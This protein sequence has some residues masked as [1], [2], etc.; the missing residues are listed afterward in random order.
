MAEVVFPWNR[1]IYLKIQLISIRREKISVKTP[2]P[3]KQ[4]QT[5]VAQR[6]VQGIKNSFLWFQIAMVAVLLSS[7]S[8]HQPVM[9]SMTSLRIRTLWPALYL[10][11]H[12]NIQTMP[13]KSMTTVM[14]LKISML[15]S[16]FIRSRS[17]YLLYVSRSRGTPVFAGGV[18]KLKKNSLQFRFM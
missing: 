2:N 14:E 10:N 15:L 8:G 6:R 12:S 9:K 1:K 7:P 4:I 3:P 11:D 18:A 5:F 13:F 16:A 17:N